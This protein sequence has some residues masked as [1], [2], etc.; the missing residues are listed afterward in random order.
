MQN[1]NTFQPHGINVEYPFGI[2]YIKNW[3]QSP[4]YDDVKK[5]NIP[6]FSFSILRKFFVT[7]F[8]STKDLKTFY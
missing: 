7:F 8:I 1:L 4:G 6:L 3:R 5:I 2:P